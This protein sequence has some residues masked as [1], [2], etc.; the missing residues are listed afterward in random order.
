MT[1][2][3]NSSF[4]AINF[5]KHDATG[6][7]LFCGQVPASMIELQGDNVV[8]GVA[9]PTLDYVLNGAIAS[10][11]ANSA[12]LVGMTLTRLPVPCSINIAG[13]IH[14]S[15]EDTAELSFSLAG[16]YQVVVSAW[17]VLD[18]SFQVTQA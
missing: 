5:V 12:A 1:D 16:T 4:E 3:T 9:D 8:I 14:E 11:P 10:R 7:I 6:R 17:P 18:A 13:T 15:S 2:T